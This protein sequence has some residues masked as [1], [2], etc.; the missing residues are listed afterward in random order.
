MPP[1]L[2]A[3]PG[4]QPPPFGSCCRSES[5]CASD[6]VPALD[7]VIESEAKRA[8]EAMEEARQAAVGASVGQSS[9]YQEGAKLAHDGEAALAART[10]AA[11]ARAFMQARDRF[12]RAMP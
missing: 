2:E 9:A 11:S 5:S 12:R 4:L 7:D 8:R 10:Y 6:L 3:I 1:W